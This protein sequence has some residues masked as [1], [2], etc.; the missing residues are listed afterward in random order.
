MSDTPDMETVIADALAF[1]QCKAN[2]PRAED[3][4]SGYYQF[5]QDQ[6]EF[7]TDQQRATARAVMNAITGTGPQQWGTRDR[8]G[9][10]QRWEDEA[11]AKQMAHGMAQ[12][13][14]TRR[15]GEW[16]KVDGW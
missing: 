5:S 6:R 1:E 8:H 2:N 9:R 13:L 12:E 14:V 3:P 16:E 15:T 4:I 7:L 10:V 11:D